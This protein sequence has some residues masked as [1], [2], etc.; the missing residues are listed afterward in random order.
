MADEI[1]EVE[2]DRS[3]LDLAI[4]KAFSKYRQLSSNSVEESFIFI[5]TQPDVQNYTLSDEV[6]EV[7]RTWR[8]GV[9]DSGSG[10]NIDPFDLSL[11]Q[12]I[13]FLQAGALGGLSLFDAYSQYKEL[14]GRVFGSEYNFLWNRNT[15][16]LKLL[17]KI[18]HTEAIAIEVQNF[19]PESILLKDIYASPWVA[20]WA[21]AQSKLMLGEARSKYLSGLPGAGGQIQLNGEQ[22]K[23]EAKEEMEGLL[24]GI[25]NLEE[26]SSPY[27]FTIG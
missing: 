19:I 24:E 1:V 16:E 14:I 15:H 23:S 5:Q 17:R 21:L 9:G 25:K 11:H 18:L 6:I 13:Y 20:D 4:D 8:R 3:H 10:T 27:G 2:L 7:T 12:N 26:G 22:L